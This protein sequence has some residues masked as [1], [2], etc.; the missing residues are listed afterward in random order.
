M[1]NNFDD[2]QLASSL[3]QL[4]KINELATEGTIVFLNGPWGSGKTYFWKNSLQPLFDKNGCLY[5]SLFGVQSVANL[6]EKL[7]SAIIAG[8]QENGLLAKGRN[9]ISQ[10]NI[11][12]NISAFFNKHTGINLNCDFLELISNRYVV[13][14]DDLERLPNNSD[15][16]EI[17]GFINY[18][19]EHRGYSCLVILNESEIK[20]T[21]KEQFNRLKEKLSL[22]TFQLP[23][24][25]IARFSA[26]FKTKALIHNV[27]ISAGEFENLETTIQNIKTDNLRT[28]RFI[29]DCYFQVR[30][31][32]GKELP[33]EV[34]KFLVA[35]IDHE[36]KGNV[37]P[38]EFYDF[39]PMV[40]Y[41]RQYR[42]NGK[43]QKDQAP[44]A[45]EDF[46]FKYFGE[47]SQYKI[48]RCIYDVVRRGHFNADLANQEIFPTEA[49]L[50]AT[51][52]LAQQI[53]NTH[54][55]F[56]ES[57]ELKELIEQIHQFL[58]I[59]DGLSFATIFTFAKGLSSAN[60]L[61]ELP[62]IT[63]IPEGFDRALTEAA[64]SVD[65]PTQYTRDFAHRNADMYQ[66]FSDCF[67]KACND[68]NKRRLQ[69]AF[70][71]AITSGTTQKFTDHTLQSP[72]LLE[73][74]FTSGQIERVWTSTVM[75]REER[76][77]LLEVLIKLMVMS[78][79]H[80]LSA[81]NIKA[82]LTK[83]HAFLRAKFD[84]TKD[85]MVRL[86][87]Y[88]LLEDCGMEMPSDSPIAAKR[89][90]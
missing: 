11:P 54:F 44:D 38:S 46:L 2:G 32:V 28:V 47:N 78:S 10:L 29:L 4:L 31:A 53:Q 71:D 41:A 20:G 80:G 74:I 22:R 50:S 69:N 75:T 5:V 56:S 58:K 85:K 61:L 63:V 52:K 7:L 34:I 17:L 45:Q 87:I 72:Q 8:S 51:E 68:E 76:Q 49:N 25:L 42:T 90:G 3:E 30:C 6:K 18:L 48:F 26:F 13:C 21:R 16:E 86:R 36:S 24:D 27:E 40:I 81:A 89:G 82:E 33:L 62:E 79:H 60:R 83:T 12:A 23:F 70:N 66:L 67:V 73:Q 57:S 15:V 9:F 77:R 35:M 14:F 19:S 65:N 1:E 88:R 43:N 59:G 37:E 64:K 84:E 55:F 39:N